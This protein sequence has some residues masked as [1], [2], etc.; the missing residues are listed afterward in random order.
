MIDKDLLL[1]VSRNDQERANADKWLN[2]SFESGGGEG[3]REI[4]NAIQLSGPELREAI[5]SMPDTHL[6]NVSLLA[7]LAFAET[8]ERVLLSE[9]EHDV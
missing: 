4:W 7:S 2:D 9:H 5:A 6:E 1:L 3:I 8:V